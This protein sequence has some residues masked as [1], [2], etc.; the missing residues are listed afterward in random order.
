MASRINNFKFL[1][2]ICQKNVLRNQK[3]IQCSKF[4]FWI[5]AK[6]NDVSNEEFENLSNEMDNVPWYF[7]NWEIDKNASIFV[8]ANLPVKRPK[9]GYLTYYSPFPYFFQVS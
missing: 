8:L 4:C 3:F 5:H 6:C 7:I 2:G 1:C 9:V